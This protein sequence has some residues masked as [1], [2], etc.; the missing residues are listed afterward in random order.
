M[1]KSKST[2][3]NWRKLKLKRLWRRNQWENADPLPHWTPDRLRNQQPQLYGEV[4]N[5]RLAEKSAWG[6]IRVLAS[7]S[8]W[9]VRQQPS[10]VPQR[11]NR[12]ILRS[13][14]TE[15]Q[16]LK[17][18]VQQRVV[19]MMPHIKNGEQVCAL[20][21]RTLSSLS[22]P[23]VPAPK[24][25]SSEHQTA[26]L[27]LGRTEWSQESSIDAGILGPHNND[28][29]QPLIIP[30]SGPPV[31]RP[32][33]PQQRLQSAISASLLNI[34]VRW[35]TLEIWGKPPSWNIHIE[36]IKQE[37]VAGGETDNAGN[38]RLL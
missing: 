5:Q 38:K 12:F 10:T 13:T 30:L 17:M 6:I 37:N 18:W 35:Q 3:Q 21:H 33:P 19:T 1:E 15:I 16:L 9:A 4:S 2:W 34:T 28:P 23:R 11:Y 24:L 22:R 31:D 14:E 26:G 27:F 36:T 20:S 32:Q 25:T 29:A 7:P 8:L